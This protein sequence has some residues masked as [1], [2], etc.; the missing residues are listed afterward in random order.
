MLFII[1]TA[2]LIAKNHLKKSPVTG[3]AKYKDA[4]LFKNVAWVICFFTFF[5]Q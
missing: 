5:Y 3:N 4:E 2:L 1:K